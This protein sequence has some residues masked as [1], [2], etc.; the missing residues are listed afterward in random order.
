MKNRPVYRAMFEAFPPYQWSRQES[1]LPTA[2]AALTATLF[3][4]APAAPKLARRRRTPPDTGLSV[5]MLPVSKRVYKLII[6]KRTPFTC[7]LSLPSMRLT[8]IPRKELP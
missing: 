2:T 6:L 5:D 4:L 8:C 1:N 7:K 3:A